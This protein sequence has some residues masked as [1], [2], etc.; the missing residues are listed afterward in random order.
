MHL[1]FNKTTS[2]FYC[3][4]FTPSYPLNFTRPIRFAGYSQ[5]SLMWKQQENQAHP[6]RWKILFTT[7][8]SDMNGFSL[9]FWFSFSLS[10]F[11][12][13]V[14]LVFRV[15]SQNAGR[16]LYR[17]LLFLSCFPEPKF[18]PYV[19]IHPYEVFFWFSAKV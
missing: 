1:V 4:N 7:E 2:L 14:K 12:S 15:L 19:S 5:K 9:H 13:I 18:P 6:F 17:I 8:Y 16:D 11:Q 10:A 3:R